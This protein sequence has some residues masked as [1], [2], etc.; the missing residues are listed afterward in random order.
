MFTGKVV[1]DYLNPLIKGS[2]LKVVKLPPYAQPLHMIMEI[3]AAVHKIRKDACHVQQQFMTTNHLA[4]EI[5][6]PKTKEKKL[7][8]I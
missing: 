2:P 6:S 5:V 8:K 3:K 4:Q 1:W 7:R